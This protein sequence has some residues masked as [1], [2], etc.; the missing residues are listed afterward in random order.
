MGVGFLVGGICRQLYKILIELVGMESS[1][2][3]WVELSHFYSC[4]WT[5]LGVSRIQD[6]ISFLLVCSAVLGLTPACQDLDGCS[7]PGLQSSTG[8]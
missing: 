2:Y 3:D 8:G 7:D 4:S 1:S 6:V 5:S